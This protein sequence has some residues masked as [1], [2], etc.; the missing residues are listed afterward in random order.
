MRKLRRE[1]SVRMLMR[2]ILMCG[3]V[4]KIHALHGRYHYRNDQIRTKK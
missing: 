2:G 1:A 3:M 4:N